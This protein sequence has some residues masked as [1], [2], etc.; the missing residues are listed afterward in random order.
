VQITLIHHAALGDTVLLIPLLR[1]LRIRFAAEEPFITL[2]TRPDFGRL[3]HS[4]GHIDA[5]ASAD[6]PAH[7]AWFG[8]AALIPPPWASADLLLS[9]VSTGH[10]AWAKNARQHCRGTL[11]F[12]EPRPPTHYPRHVTQWHREQLA[13]LHLHAPPMPEPATVAD[14]EVMI[15]PGSGGIAKCWPLEN[16]VALAEQLSTRPLL[17][18]LGE[19]ERERWGGAAVSTLQQRF[20]T[21]EQEDLCLL[22]QR[23]STCRLY[24]GNDSGITHLAAAMGTPVLALF[25]PSH[26]VQW[27]PVGRNVSVLSGGGDMRELSVEAV[28][29]RVL[30]LLNQ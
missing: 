23:L 11:L 14:G 21:V 25:G 24:V 17:F 12:F 9:A 2:V 26:E 1:A 3:L 22:A 16:F 28:I 5:W 27:R 13:V 15:H 20:A 19:A 7:V 4:L 6:A 18:L 10:D 29:A 8:S 30:S